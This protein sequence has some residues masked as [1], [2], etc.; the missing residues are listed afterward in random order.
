MGFTLRPYQQQAVDATLAHFRKSD[1]SA[2]LVL[3]TGSGKSLVIAELARLARRNI[4]V[5]THVQ[6]L[7]EQNAAKFAVL[8]R[9]PGIYSAGLRQRDTQHP[10]IFGSIQ[11][12]AANLEQFANAYSLLVIDE[13][14]RI[15]DDSESQY[16]QVIAHL[17]SINPGLK[18]LGLTAT[19]YRLGY[20][21]IYQRDYR[22][23]VRSETPRIFE[24]CIFELPLRTLIKQGYLTPPIINKP[25]IA[26]YDFSA[27]RPNRDGLFAETDL[28]ELLS[29]FPR[30]TEAI[31]QQLVELAQQRQG[32]MIFAATVKHAKEILG[33]LPEG[34][35]AVVIA[36]TDA[37]TRQSII[38]RFKQRKLKFLVNVSVLTTGFDAPHVD[39][40]ALLRPTQSVSLFQQMV[41]RGLRLSESKNDCL[42]I[43]YANNGIDL[44]D[45]EVGEP[46]PAADTEPVQ[47]FCPECG[48]AN[49]FWGRT[50]GDGAVIEHFGR[51]CQGLLED[52]ET[53]SEQC[54]FRFKFKRCGSCA[55]ENDIAARACHRCQ[56][57]LI[58]PDELIK[59]ALSLKDHKVIRCAG[60]TLSSDAGAVRLTYHDEDG[61]TLSEKFDLS[62]RQQRALFNAL[63]GRR[64]NNASQPIRF[65]SNEQL[66]SFTEHFPHPDFVV[67]RKQGKYW[68]ISERLFD[69]QG[70]YRRANEL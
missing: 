38:A 49:L 4:L 56:A 65:E 54:T 17:R 36:E 11:S 44:Y 41:G 22:G 1:A 33:Y 67:S 19:P 61:Q 16:Q 37:Q 15:S 13:A 21:W 42:V 53:P 64:I 6:E 43:D 3:P 40:I 9:Q 12:V 52:E 70:V 35:A 23:F 59:R 27:L 46:K 28:N 58:D 55:A 68:R 57:D 63:F 62:N 7:V 69:Y 10:V 20:G 39:L 5:L 47:V 2:L 45:P 66:L 26:H 34:E 18:V 51:R 8:G 32:I 24:R 29:R 50:D 30:V 48:H 25:A 31:C 60:I 14:H